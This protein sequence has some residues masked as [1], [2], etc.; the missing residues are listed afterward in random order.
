[1]NT[2]RSAA[3]N[4][5]HPDVDNIYITLTLFYSIFCLT[6]PTPKAF[7]NC[8]FEDWAKLEYS[9]FLIACLSFPLHV[10]MLF[11]IRSSNRHLINGAMSSEPALET[12]LGI[13][14]WSLDLVALAVGARGK[15]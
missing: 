9:R 10:Y 7:A 12:F 2:N 4:S 6:V 14:F 1:M 11:M 15:S 8:M 3:S 5:T 13:F